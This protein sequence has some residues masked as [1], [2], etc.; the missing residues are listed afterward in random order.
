[1]GHWQ[2]IRR[3]ARAWR[4]EVFGGTEGA[5]SAVALL[6][7]AERYTGIRRE[8]VAAGDPLLHGG[9]AAL[10]AENG[11]IWYDADANLGLVAFYQAHEYAHLWLGGGHAS[12]A[13]PDVDDEAAEEPMPLGVQRVE[14]YGPHE[15]REREANVFAREFLLPTDVLC[16]WYLEGLD[17]ARIAERVGVPE[18]MVL[19]QLS[20][21]LLTPE[22]AG[23]TGCEEPVEDIAGLD[24]SQREAALAEMG[25]VMLEA[26]PGTGKTHTLVGRIL[27][28]VESGV[29]PSSILALTFSNKAAEEMRSRVA[30][31]APEA[32]PRI[33]MDTFHAFGLE[34]LRK[35]GTLLGLPPLP[36]PAGCGPPPRPALH[37]CRRPR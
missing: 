19:H 28:L 3:A 35:D 15:R 26:G 33:W 21:A 17:P 2:D 37:A 4:A 11:V 36:C 7:A 8:P 18:G 22:I 5:P 29:N 34:L 10:D 20:R 27:F 13:A 30:R 24:P 16:R 25:P 1:M 6:E 14:G 12:C 9:V 32:A 23:Q 31:V